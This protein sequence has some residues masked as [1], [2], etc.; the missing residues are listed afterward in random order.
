MIED[1]ARYS[2]FFVNTLFCDYCGSRTRI[3]NSHFHVNSKFAF[4]NDCNKF[5]IGEYYIY[6][7]HQVPPDDPGMPFD[8]W[9]RDRRARE[10]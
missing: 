6:L 10:V 2:L 8:L 7:D 4:C 3:N 9:F 5:L 1:T